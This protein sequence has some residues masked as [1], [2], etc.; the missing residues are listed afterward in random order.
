MDIAKDTKVIYHSIKNMKETKNINT[1]NIITLTTALISTIEDIIGDRD[2]RYKKKIL[3]SVIE[4]VIN[5]SKLSIDEKVKLQILVRETLGRVIDT[6]IDV[7]YGVIDLHKR[8]K[9]EGYKCFCF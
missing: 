1:T 9:E 7:S 6:L 8:K 2:G 4:E 5:D 3:L